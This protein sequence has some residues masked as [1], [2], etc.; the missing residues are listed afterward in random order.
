MNS[1]HVA[2]VS[3]RGRRDAH[4][5][6]VS[7]CF[8]K[9]AFELPTV[10]G[11][12]DQIAERDAIAVQVLLDPGGED[13]AG[14]SRTLL[15]KGPEQQSAANITGRVLNGGQVQALGLGP[16]VWDIV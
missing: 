3:M 8:G 16:V 5:L 15:R 7:E 4:V 9:V 11:L 13:G 1:L 14:R 10:V 2:L 6:A 12:P